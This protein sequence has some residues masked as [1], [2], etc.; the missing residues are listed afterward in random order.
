MRLLKWCLERPQDVNFKHNRKHITVVLFSI[1][2]TKWIV[3]NT[4]K[5]AVAYSYIFR[6]ISCGRIQSVLKRCP[7]SGVVGTSPR[8]QSWTSC[9]DLFSLHNF[10]FFLPNLCLKHYKVS[11]FNVLCFTSYKLLKVTPR[12]WRS[13]D[14]SR[15]SI[16]NISSKLIS[17][18]IFSV[19]VEEMWV[20]DSNKLSALQ[21]T[22]SHRQLPIVWE[23]W[24]AKK[25]WKLQKMTDHFSHTQK[26]GFSN[27]QTWKIFFSNFIT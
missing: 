12:G 19:L 6:E 4:E 23:H 13:L 1:L 17:V 9:K 27:C 24:S 3:W 15:A 2:L 20:L 25:T 21:I 26:K 14:D 10:H 18:K 8:H 11:C 7:L 22:V 16:F 5:L